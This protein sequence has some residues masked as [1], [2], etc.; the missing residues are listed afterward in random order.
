MTKAPRILLTTGG[1]A[2][3]LDVSP[4]RVAQLVELRR[5]FPSPYAI[6]EGGKTPI[7][8]W[9]R[10]DVERWKDTADRRVGKRHNVNGN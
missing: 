8:L 9:R 2:K 1:V 7:R 5:D 10:E 4:R 6:T 3:V